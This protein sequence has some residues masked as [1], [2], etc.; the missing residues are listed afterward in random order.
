M[1]RAIKVPACLMLISLTLVYWVPMPTVLQIFFCVF[2][3]LMVFD[4]R[5]RF[6]DYKRLKQQEFIPEEVI[7]L[8]RDTRCGREAM[9]SANPGAAEVYYDM[10][11][12]W[13]HLTPDGFFTRDTPIAKISFWAVFFRGA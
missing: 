3:F 10:G 5:G 1:I 12:R 9:I 7:F 6:G 8:F 4:V 13:Y 11:Y 2:A